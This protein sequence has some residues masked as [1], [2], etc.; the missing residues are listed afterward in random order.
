MEALQFVIDETPYCCWDWRL[1]Q[2]NL[3][4]LEGIDVEYF[5]Y[6]A[7]CN[8]KNLETDNSNQA[9]TALRLAYCHGLET[10]FA[11]LCSAI[12]AP[13][14][15]IG[16]ITSYKI[17]ELV[18][19]V[20]KIS[21]S[22]SVYSRLLEKQINWENLSCHVHAYI[23]YEEEKKGW[24]IQG[25]GRLWANFA[26]EFIDE[27]LSLEYNG[28]KHGLRAK[29]GGFYMAIGHEEKMG[30]PPPPEKW[31]S[32]GGSKYG[33]SYFVKEII[34]KTNQFHFR[35]RHHSTN[36]NPTN[37]AHGLVLISMSINNVVSWLRAINGVQLEKCKFVSPSSKEDFEAPWAEPV[38]ITHSSLDSSIK[39]K[40]IDLFSKEKIIKS[41]KR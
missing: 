7:E 41:Y 39:E 10:L 17:I 33:T 40:D 13:R 22:E 14:C 15:S 18:N 26:S 1:C 30:V 34:S 16:W 37:L 5:E 21:R 24:I 20:K 36:W 8:V 29:P 11:L 23:D 35:P 6:V 31:M 32:L 9:A 19:I 3:E 38:D 28:I 4:F 25:F 27:N 12:Q 2:K